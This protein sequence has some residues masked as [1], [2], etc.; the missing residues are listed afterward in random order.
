MKLPKIKNWV[1]GFTLIEIV[2]VISVLGVLAV[3]TYSYAVPKYRNRTYYTRGVAEM[4][5]MANAVTLYVAKYNDYPPDVV[6]GV[7]AGMKE[8]IQT[9]GVNAAW[10]NA[11]WPDTVYDW[12]SWPPDNNG[13]LQTYQIT[14]RF[15]NAGDNAT[16]KANAQKYL[17]GY[18]DST[19]LNNWDAL[20]SV[21]YCIKGSCRA[22]Q[23]QPMNHAGY[24]INCG[25]KSQIF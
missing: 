7:P 3:I 22:H 6:R 23:S 4:N 11:P 20:S 5:A 15:C 19:T 18:V 24:C 8:F 25:N 17:T 10:P 12:D 2:A 14:V 21:Y 13:P 9:D 16:C 1:S